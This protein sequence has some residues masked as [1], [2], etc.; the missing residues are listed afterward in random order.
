MLSISRTS[1]EKTGTGIA[2]LNKDKQKEEEQYPFIDYQLEIVWWQVNTW[3][4]PRELWL[5]QLQQQMKT[6]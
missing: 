3:L 4:N 6:T 5:P 2:R 1:Q